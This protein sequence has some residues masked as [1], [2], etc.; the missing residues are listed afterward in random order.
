MRRYFKAAQKYGFQIMTKNI[1]VNVLAGHEGEREHRYKCLINFKCINKKPYLV[2]KSM[3]VDN[4][5]IPM[6]FSVIF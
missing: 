3:I 2:K 5:N 1:R 6:L 4:I